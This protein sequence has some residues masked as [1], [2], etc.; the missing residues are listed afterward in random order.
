MYIIFLY[1]LSVAA[2]AQL[3]NSPSLEPCAHMM[4]SGAAFCPDT[5][6]LVFDSQSGYWYAEGAWRSA[7]KSFSEEMSVFVGAQWSGTNVGRV[8]CIYRSKNRGEFP[9]QIS[10]DT[11]VIKP[12]NIR[13][14]SG[15]YDPDMALWEQDPNR[16]SALNCKPKGGSV[17]DCPFFLLEEPDIPLDQ[18]I[19]SIHKR[20]S[21]ESWMYI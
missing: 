16:A 14:R 2:H 13:D 1:I 11:L 4:Q 9:V 7:E 19:K 6:D 20:S 15:Y 12:D 21:E 18:Q 17:C 3:D 5:R 10:R 8:A